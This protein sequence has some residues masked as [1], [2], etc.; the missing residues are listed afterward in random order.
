MRLAGAGQGIRDHRV[1]DAE[2]ERT[3]AAAVEAV[4]ALKAKVDIIIRLAEVMF[5]KGPRLEWSCGRAIAQSER[6]HVG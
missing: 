6:E 4:S 2:I 1:G 3:M 5:S